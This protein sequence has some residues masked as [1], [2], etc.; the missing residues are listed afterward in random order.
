MELRDLALLER[1]KGDE[2][3]AARHIHSAYELE[4][5]AAD[6]LLHDLG[7]EPARSVLYRS[8]ATLA[9]DCGRFAEAEKLIHRALGGNPRAEIAEE[10]R[11]LLEEVTFS[12]HLA[13]RGVKLEEEEIQMALTGKAVGFGV[14][15]TDVFLMRVHSTENLLYRTAE[16]QQKRE[17]RERGRRSAK[18]EQD[19]E[20]YMSVPR[21]ACFAV[22]FRVGEA[23]EPYLPGFS[24][25]ESVIDELLDCLE[26]YTQGDLTKLKERIKEEAYYTNFVALARTL[27][28]DG[29][30]VDM[31]GFTAVRRGKVKQVA[32]KRAISEPQALRGDI[33]Q[34]EEARAV[35]TSDKLVQFRGVL[36]IA[37]AKKKTNKQSGT[38]EV[39][40]PGNVGQ[41]LTVPPG[42]MVDIVRP[43]WESEVV[44]TG[45]RK[46]KKVH[47]VEIKPAS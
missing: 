9:R 25:S 16:R 29:A 34:E 12:R 21:A 24:R 41:K 43:L 3:S 38:I 32:L 17:F 7:A 47:L 10:L 31:V 13:L 22:T 4:S 15:P 30:K 27:Q 14:A 8:A 35:T 5:Q 44:V 11:D 39:V 33:V 45:L 20:L 1:R 19:V 28:P 18:I 23:I 37:N 36:L 46:G 26:I 2:E 40:M 6:T 42:M